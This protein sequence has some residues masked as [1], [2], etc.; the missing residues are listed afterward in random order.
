MSLSEKRYGKITGSQVHILFPKRSNPKTFDSYARTLAKEKVFRFR[1]EAST[2]QMEH[3]H[4]G[5]ELAFAWFKENV[6]GGAFKPDYIEKGEFGAS[7][8][9][10]SSLEYGVDFK[11]PTTLEKWLSYLDGIDDQQYHQCQHY[12]FMW[13]MNEWKILAYLTE[14]IKMIDNGDF[15]PIPDDK[16]MIEFSVK[17]DPLWENQLIEKSEKLINLR[18]SYVKK[19]ESILL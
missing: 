10:I 11:C 4:M 1:D 18:D 8:D 19:Y 14:T 15:Y 3:G 5:E 12:M 7:V 9:C 6:D 2:W 17:K 13:K 16:R